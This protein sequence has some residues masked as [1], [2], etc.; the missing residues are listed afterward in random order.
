MADA[1]RGLGTRSAWHALAIGA[2]ALLPFTAHAAAAPLPSTATVTAYPQPRTLPTGGAGPLIVGPDGNVWFTQV[3]EEIY[4]PGG[5]PHYLPRIVRMDPLGQIGIVA[6]HMRAESFASTADG[7]VWFTGGF[8]SIGR[9][10]PDGTIDSFALPETETESTSAGGGANGP[11]VAGADGNVWFAAY[12]SPKAGMQGETVAAIDR[13]TPSGEITEFPL[14]GAG[15]SPTRLALGHDGNV[16]FTERI[17]DRVGSISRTGRI[18]SFPLPPASRPGNIVAGSDGALW[19]TEESDRGPMLGRL[20]TSGAFREFPLGANENL[21]AGALAAGPDGRLWFTLEAG[22][23][24]RMSPQGRISRVQLPH[25]TGVTQI[26]A[27]PEGNLWYSAL[28]GPPCAPG[29][30]GC[31][32]GGYFEAG[33]IGRVEPAPLGV[34]IDSA[35]PARHG[36]RVKVRISCLDGKAGS[37]CRGKLRLR[38]GPALVARRSF[39]LGVDRSRSFGLKLRRGARAKLLRAGHLQIVCRATFAGGG[40]ESRSLLVKLTRRP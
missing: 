22:A 40:T 35:K 2:L 12:R 3:Y 28:A 36:R 38:H 29:D 37:V 10:R 9:V 8:R 11:I 4:V 34:A 25:A 19:F 33:I 6:E 13:I 15:G 32:D 39:R 7:S 18:T 30:S 17:E 14:P 24:H 1:V 5:E 21:S 23:I 20:A 31:G 16:W 26:V 27:G